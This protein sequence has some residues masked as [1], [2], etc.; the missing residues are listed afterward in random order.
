MPDQLL[1]AHEMMEYVYN[2]A[3]V[4]YPVSIRDQMNRARWLVQKAYDLGFFGPSRDSAYRRL[5]VCGAGAAGVTAALHA[6]SLGVETVLVERSSAP[7]LCQRL[8]TS[9]WLDPAQYDW[10]ADFWTFGRFPYPPAPAMPLP[11]PALRSN[12]VA[13]AWGPAWLAARGNPLL[14]FRRRDYVVG[15]P[16]PVMA[17]GTVVGVRVNF[18]S[19]AMPNLFGMM[20]WCVGFGD[21]R[22]FAPPSYTGFAF[23]ETDPFERPLWGVSPVPDDLSA[24]VS[25]G[26]DG[27]LQDVIRLTT[28]KKS[29]L[30]VYQE[31]VRAGWSLPDDV[32]HQL[33]TAEDQAQ[34]VLLW[35]APRSQDEHNALQ[36][37]HEAYEDAVTKVLAGPSAATLMA[38]VQGL[39]VAKRTPGQ[40]VL[41]VHPCT[42][43]ARVYGL[44]HFL[45]LLLAKVAAMSSGAG[46]LQVM[47]QVGVAQVTGVDPRH[48]C[49]TP[50][51]CH[52][53]E[54][55][56]TLEH[57]A[58]CVGPAAPGV[59]AG[60]RRAHVVVIRHGIAPHPA[61]ASTPMAFARQVMPYYLP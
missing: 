36:Q 6:L 3:D 20:L 23:W 51:G 32:R 29:A 43:F 56:V 2:V 40:P 39:F 45:V 53:I 9:R 50:S 1:R 11:W 18:R 61:F 44:N 57:R 15:A 42:H 27:A 28:G 35:C 52:G 47:S 38:T 4:A 10:P 46:R 12:R 31:L 48:A 49:A 17:R 34:R 33:F 14:T 24:L 19:G 7:F 21:E 55:D 13:L 26:G 5:L 8:C 25:G 16:A 30:E 37:L 60:S 54:H 41:L 22:R 59:I 58:S